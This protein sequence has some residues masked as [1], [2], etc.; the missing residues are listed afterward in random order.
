MQDMP[1][2]II[3]FDMFYDN[4]SKS[5]PEHDASLSLV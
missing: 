5:F 2:L 1:T 3:M 4:M